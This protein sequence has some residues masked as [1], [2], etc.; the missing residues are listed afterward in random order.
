MSYI[1]P[2]S[3]PSDRRV[4]SEG[5]EHISAGYGYGSGVVSP[6]SK[7]SPSHW[8]CDMRIPHRNGILATQS[9]A[10]I[11]H[12]LYFRRSRQWQNTNFDLCTQPTHDSIHLQSWTG[13]LNGEGSATHVELGSNNHLGRFEREPREG[14]LCCKPIH[15]FGVPE[16][17]APIAMW[18]NVVLL[19]EHAL[20]GCPS[21]NPS[22]GK[23]ISRAEKN[24]DY[25]TSI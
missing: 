15:G 16:N 12:T 17:L 7:R 25:T 19:R 14:R 13:P 21:W 23:R 2:G 9:N 8:F 5:S 20:R 11:W 22:P 18:G 1:I 10:D 6:S 4:L 24:L 3:L